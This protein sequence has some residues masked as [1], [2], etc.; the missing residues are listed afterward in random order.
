MGK[1]LHFT[2]KTTA[3]GIDWGHQ[4]VKVVGLQKRGSKFRLTHCALFTM[5]SD[6]K[7]V[8]VEEKIVKKIQS[9]HGRDVP[10][11][12]SVGGNDVIAR[13]VKL[14]DMP[15]REF[16]KAAIWE[17]RDQLY[18]DVEDAILWSDYF[19][20]I[21][22]GGVKKTHGVAYAVRKSAVQTGL[23][24]Y[25]NLS[26]YSEMVILSADADRLSLVGG[27]KEPVLFL[28]VGHSRTQIS[29]VRRGRV[30]FLRDANFGAKQI[31]DEIS[32]NLGISAREAESAM[33]RM[34]LQT[35]GV[36][37]P[38]LSY[39]EQDLEFLFQFI[40][41]A[42]EPLVDEIQ[43]SLQFFSSQF[44]ENVARIA[45][46]GGGVLNSGFERYIGEKIGL[47]AE[48]SNPFQSIEMDK[49]D[50]DTEALNKIAPI[51][52]TAVGLAKS[53]FVS[54]REN[55]NILE[56]I[57]QKKKTERK[58]GAVFRL[59]SL[60]AVFLIV[61]FELFFSYRTTTLQ[62]KKIILDAKY[63][64]IQYRLKFLKEL[65][66]KTGIMNSRFKVLLHTKGE[67]PRWSVVL[68]SLG[69][70]IPRGT[71]ITD[72]EALPPSETEEG[73]LES[74]SSGEESTAAQWRLTIKG[75]SYSGGNVRIFYNQL[76]KMPY[77]SDVTIS[78]LALSDEEQ[79]KNLL[80][81]EISCRMV[82]NFGQ[83]VQAKNEY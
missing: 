83:I 79:S 23:V 70:S 68:K 43:L 22:E 11:V 25:Q 21:T 39:S 73:D 72:F 33:R 76:Q 49:N 32:S 45:L 47:P 19:G 34:I 59:T 12:V 44:H 20:K 75:K 16:R 10:V 42:L 4:S 56:I 41:M 64:T 24:K 1:R 62:N 54:D 37:I 2:A 78:R 77:F 74:D 35:G 8:T 26:L 53:R 29:I 15:E 55:L 51:F 9:W 38:G 58:K 82:E 80:E 63:K 17:I 48:K 30:V 81:F 71:W 61:L 13:Y 6:G 65:E 60:S 46:F 66:E 69:R 18:F 67:Q 7:E 3:F 52:S 14:P 5:P 28:N 27:T 57:K 31:R 40:E 36:R 50:F